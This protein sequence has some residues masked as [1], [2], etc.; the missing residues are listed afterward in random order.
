REPYALI[1]GR[2]LIWVYDWYSRDERPATGAESGEYNRLASAK[3]HVADW[4]TT[5][6]MLKSP[7][8]KRVAW[9][10]TADAEQQ[11]VRAPLTIYASDTS[12]RSDRRRCMAFECT[13]QIL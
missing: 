12:E 8:R 10:E 11:G 13:G 1:D 2:P 6:S 9:L 7:D 3:L 5:R 4:P